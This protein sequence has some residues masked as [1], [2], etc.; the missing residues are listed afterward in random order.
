MANPNGQPP[1]PVSRKKLSRWMIALLVG[2][3]CIL[4]LGG[5]NICQ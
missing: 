4:V 5:G 3:V 1:R 2:L